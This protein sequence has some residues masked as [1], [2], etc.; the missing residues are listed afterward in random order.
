MAQHLP[1]A[2]SASFAERLRQA[3]SLDVHVAEDGMTLRPGA[4]VLAPG[5]RHLVIEGTPA[6]PLCRLDAGPKVNRHRPSVDVLFSSVAHVMSAQA[7]GVLL[8]GMG[9]DGAQGMKAM[10][11]AGATTLV[12]DRDSSMVWGMPRAAIRT[13]AVEHILSLAEIS[14]YLSRV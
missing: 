10:H 14:A 12:Q 6:T 4:L 8:T 2:F 9:K 11:D 3:C 1:S 5:D 13:G 7:V